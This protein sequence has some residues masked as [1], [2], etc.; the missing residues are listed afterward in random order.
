[1][2]TVVDLMEHFLFFRK[3]VEQIM[4]EYQLLVFNRRWNLLRYKAA[5]AVEAMNKQS[6][7]EALYYA[8]SLRHE[9]SALHEIIHDSGK[10]LKVCVALWWC[11][12]AD[13]W[14]S[15]CVIDISHV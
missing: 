14:L 2:G 6:F 9:V 8:H 12:N 5:K 7:D 13:G 10:N 1:M 11:C 15:V 4:T 3:E